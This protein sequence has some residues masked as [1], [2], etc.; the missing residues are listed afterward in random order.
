ML[1]GDLSLVGPR[2]PIPYEAELY[3]PWHLRRVLEGRPGI[4]GLWQV[5]GRN[6]VSFDEMVRMDLRYTRT[7]TLWLDIK[8][9]AKTVGAVLRFDGDK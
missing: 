6:R 2:P 3:Q 9:L 1:K 8:L 4:T 7:W 5:E